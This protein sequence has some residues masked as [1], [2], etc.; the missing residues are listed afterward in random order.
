[1]LNSFALTLI[2]KGKEYGR[3]T[4]K[5]IRR[6]AIPKNLGASAHDAYL[7]EARIEIELDGR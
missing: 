5:Y 2:S 1:M 6:S 7:G 4:V 3:S